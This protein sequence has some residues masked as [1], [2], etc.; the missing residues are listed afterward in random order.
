MP[1]ERALAQHDGLVALAAAVTP[2]V[3]PLGL[4]ATA[5]LRPA[6]VVRMLLVPAAGIV[7]RLRCV[8]RVLVATV[9]VAVVMGALLMAGSTRF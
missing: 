5:V 2:H 3:V 6:S 8:Q 9:L 7:L 4:F 1:G